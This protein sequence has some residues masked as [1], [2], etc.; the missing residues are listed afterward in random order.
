M[1]K[2]LENWHKSG[3]T[4]IEAVEASLESYKKSKAEAA[5]ANAAQTAPIWHPARTLALS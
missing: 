2:V 3:L 5:A 1:N 4:T